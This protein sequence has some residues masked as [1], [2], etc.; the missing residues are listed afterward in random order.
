MTVSDNET[1]ILLEIVKERYG[2][3]LKDEQLAEVEFLDRW[4]DNGTS[5]IPLHVTDDGRFL[6]ITRYG[7]SRTYISIYDV[8]RGR[9]QMVSVAG[10]P[11]ARFDWSDDQQWKC[12]SLK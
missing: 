6:T 1:R 3:R 11:H 8:A 10:R 4:R 7:F 9:R 5:D 12:D 2:E